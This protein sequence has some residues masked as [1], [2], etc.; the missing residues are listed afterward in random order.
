MEWN[1]KRVGAVINT[2]GLKLKALVILRSEEMKSS[3]VEQDKQI[4]CPIGVQSTDGI[5]SSLNNIPTLSSER[6][7]IFSYH[8][9][10]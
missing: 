3:E 2:K 9:T 1:N 5:V 8:T 6:L 7:Q 10:Y 4:T